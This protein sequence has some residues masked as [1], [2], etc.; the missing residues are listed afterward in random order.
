[1]LDDT[2]DGVGRGAEESFCILLGDVSPEAAERAFDLVGGRAR[3]E[4]GESAPVWSVQ[5]PLVGWKETLPTSSV[6]VASQSL[7]APSHVSGSTQSAIENLTEGCMSLCASSCAPWRG[8][9]LKLEIWT[10]VR[11]WN[12]FQLSPCEL[13]TSLAM[14]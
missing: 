10:I 12:R 14:P 3:P 2:G 6:K 11:S 8:T 13:L 5:G 9:H 1:M 4:P 7:S